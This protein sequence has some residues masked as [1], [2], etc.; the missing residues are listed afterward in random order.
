[1]FVIAESQICDCD[2]HAFGSIGAGAF[3][4]NAFL[5]SYPYKQALPLAEAI[6]CILAAKFTS[7]RAEGIGQNTFLSLLRPGHT[8]PGL[9][10][11]AVPII[12]SW[13]IASMRAK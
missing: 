3:L 1:V 9:P 12:E 5:A 13:L 11:D 7:E 8:A 4:A 6:Y 10:A 2:L